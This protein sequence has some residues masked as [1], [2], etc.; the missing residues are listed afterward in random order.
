[1]MA[2]QASGAARFEKLLKSIRQ[3]KLIKNAE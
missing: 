3:K 2:V 1:M